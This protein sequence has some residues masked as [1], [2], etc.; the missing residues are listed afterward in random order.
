[1]NNVM[2]RPSPISRF[3]FIVLN[4]QAARPL[5]LAFPITRSPDYQIARPFF[6]VLRITG[7]SDQPITRWSPDLLMRNG[8]DP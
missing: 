3:M 1:M 7:F 5:V 4:L 2:W 8:R 6:C